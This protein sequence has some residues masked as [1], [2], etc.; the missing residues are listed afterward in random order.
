M[1]VAR[2]AAG[3]CLSRIG[4][5]GLD[6]LSMQHM[7]TTMIVA[8]GA[9]SA[10]GLPFW[11]RTLGVLALRRRSS[12]APPAGEAPI[13]RLNSGLVPAIS[14]GRSGPAG[15][16]RRETGCHVSAGLG[17]RNELLPQIPELG[18]RTIEQHRSQLSQIAALCGLGRR[19]RSGTC[20]L[21]V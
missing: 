1:T 20:R 6:C 8:A 21:N 11:Q 17:C 7:A 15:S 2:A 12:F 5:A 19:P 9:Q 10:N 18:R 16:P 14:T 3:G 13:D 4:A